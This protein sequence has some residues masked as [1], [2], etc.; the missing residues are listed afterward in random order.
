MFEATYYNIT[1]YTQKE[2][3]ESKMLDNRNDGI[4]LS[5]G[6]RDPQPEIKVGHIDKGADLIFG[7]PT[8]KV[9]LNLVNCIYSFVQFKKVFLVFLKNIFDMLYKL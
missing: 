3:S 7:I 1:H 2:A 9:Y 8:V 5:G 4:P 6:L